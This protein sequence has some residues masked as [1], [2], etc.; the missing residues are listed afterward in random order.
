ME[1]TFYNDLVSVV[2]GVVYVLG[3]FECVLVFILYL[4]AFTPVSKSQISTVF[5]L[6]LHRPWLP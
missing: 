3:V 6:I 5:I 1:D 2:V 4:C